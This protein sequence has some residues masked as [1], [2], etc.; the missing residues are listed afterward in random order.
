MNFDRTLSQSLRSL[1]RYRLRTFFIMLSAIIGV[2]ALTF[3]LSVG[4]GAQLKIMSTVRQIFGD[5]S[6]IAIAGGQQLTGGPRPDAARLTIDDIEAVAKAVP[7]IEQWDPQQSLFPTVRH[8]SAASVV[9]VLGQSERSENVWGRSV[10]R[11][12]YFDAAAVKHLD[13]VALI[14]ATA[15]ESLYGTADPIGSEIMI[16]SVPFTVIG[17]LERFGTDFHG[18]DRDNEI[19]IPVSTLLRRVANVDTIALAKFKVRP[20]ADLASTANAVKEALRIRHGLTAGQADDFSLLTPVEIRQLT[21]KISRV[22]SLYLPLASIVILL[23]GGIIAATLMVAS[24]NA[25]TAEIGLRRALG[26]LPVD[27]AKQFLTETAFSMVAGGLFGIVLGL[28]ASQAVALH[29]KLDGGLS[30]VAVVAGL[31][32][33]LLTGVVA[34]VMPARRAA[35][36]MPV[37]ALR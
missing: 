11:G 34:G 13:R 31:A 3:V 23:V 21:G 14:G 5:S 20:S 17:V 7:D 28:V 16:E 36:L 25:R 4:K 8:G 33:S 22:L 35:R 24:V 6:I 2:T 37:E 27:I 19:V 15:A 18:M 30:W 32:A 9:R 26:A 12:S 10:V 29:M 1:W